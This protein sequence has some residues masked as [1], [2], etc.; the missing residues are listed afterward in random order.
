[1]PGQGVLDWTRLLP[2]AKAAGVTEWYVEEE[3][4]I[5]TK[6]LDAIRANYAYLSRLKV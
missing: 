2:A 4:P 3:A 1:M 6:R 5:P